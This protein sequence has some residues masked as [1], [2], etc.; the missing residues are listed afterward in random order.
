VA[1]SCALCLVL[2]EAPPAETGAFLRSF[3]SIV[4]LPFIYGVIFDTLSLVNIT[5]IPPGGIYL[6]SNR[7]A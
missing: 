3:E 7:K 5:R 4:T 2:R 6:N 1:G